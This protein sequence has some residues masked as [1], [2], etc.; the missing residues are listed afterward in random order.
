MPFVCSLFAVFC[1]A[2]RESMQTLRLHR[3]SAYLRRRWLNILL[4][5][6]LGL[7]VIFAN[8]R[9]QIERPSPST[10]TLNATIYLPTASLKPILQ[11]HVNQQL[12]SDNQG[13]VGSLIHPSVTKLT[14]Q[15][16]GLAMTLS[17]SLYPGAQP[18]EVS[19]LLK[20]SVLDPSTI[21]VSAQPMPGSPALLNGPLA[22]IKVPAGHL[23]S[24]SPTPKCGDSALAAKMGFPISTGQGPVSSQ[25]ISGQPSEAIPHI[26][27][28]TANAY[29]EIPSSALSKLGK[30]LV[31]VQIN[32]IFTAQNIRISIQNNEIIVR[33][34]ISLWQTGIVVGSGTMHIQPLVKNGNLLLHMRQTDLSALFFT[35]LA[36]SYDRQ[37]EN[38]LN[39]Q[40]A[41]SL[42][43]LFTVT[44][45]AIGTDK[46]IPCMARDS[47][48]LTGTTD[49]AS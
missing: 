11:S 42:A 5:L 43:R 10:V 39:Q 28:D 33:S 32:Q 16:N 27:T 8:V 35:F 19:T 49:M 37:I 47:L 1:K 3:I 34:D 7:F 46:H 15:S 25:T 44:N 48:I 12:Q 29:V 41:A 20:F 14:P 9:G 6:L 2:D 36:D 30:D 13:W 23:N 45:V 38:S 21:Q 22:Q 40:L 17:E 31:S 4:I 26:P 24:I 18:I